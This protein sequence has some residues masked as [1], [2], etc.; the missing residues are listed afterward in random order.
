[1]KY[2]KAL[3]RRQETYPDEFN[4][5]TEKLGN[6]YFMMVGLGKVIYENIKEWFMDSGS[7]HQMNRMRSIFLS[8][9]ESDTNIFMGSG[10][11]TRQ[12]IIWYRYVIFYL[13]SGGF[14]GIKHMLYI[15]E[16]KVNLLSVVSFEDEGYAVSFQNG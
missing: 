8:F 15:P 2:V 14:L 9:L 4:G 6:R 7:S 16:L 5:L 10:T 12:E 1:M 3:V 13:K 11:N